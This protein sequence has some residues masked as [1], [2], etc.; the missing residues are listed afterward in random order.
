MDCGICIHSYKCSCVNNLIHFNV[1][2]H[3][4]VCVKFCKQN[5]QTEIV[6]TYARPTVCMNELLV[7]NGLVDIP[8][9]NNS[10]DSKENLNKEIRNKLEMIVGMNHH[11]N[12][13]NEDQ[14]NILKY[15]DKILS[16]FAKN[17][18]LRFRSTTSISKVKILSQIR[19]MSKNKIKK[20][21]YPRL[22]SAEGNIIRKALQENS[23]IL[24]INTARSDHSY[25]VKKNI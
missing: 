10:M 4:H 25:Y 18:D 1:C 20:N 3:I 7:D 19:F 12:L 9:H 23:D 24:N 11:T 2:E 13:K 15:C 5:S 14:Q 21:I 16:I 6:D 22:S 8:S 17:Q